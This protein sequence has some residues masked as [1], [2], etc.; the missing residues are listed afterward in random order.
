VT[1]LR[2]GLVLAALALCPLPAVAQ[3]PPDRKSAV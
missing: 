3:V 1:A 2:L